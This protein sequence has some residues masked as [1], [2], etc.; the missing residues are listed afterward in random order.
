MFKEINRKFSEQELKDVS[1]DSVKC[2]LKILEKHTGIILKDLSRNGFKEFKQYVS[3][4]DFLYDVLLPSLKDYNPF[5]QDKMLNANLKKLACFFFTSSFEDGLWRFVKYHT[6]NKLIEYVA[7]GCSKEMFAFKID[8]EHQDTVQTIVSTE[9]LK[10][11]FE[12]THNA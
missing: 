11:H 6:K 12:N 2:I 9:D 3:Y 7:V 1:D 10:K 8:K 4:N 5:P